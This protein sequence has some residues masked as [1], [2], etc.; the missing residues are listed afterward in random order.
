[1]R[2]RRK[3]N[4]MLIF[5]T[6]LLL[7]SIGFAALA[8]NLK[9]DGTVNVSK[10][11][12]DVH[13]ENVQV[14]Q[15]SVTATTVPTSDDTTTTE[16]TYAVNFTKP[17]DFYEFTVDI[18][19]DGTIDAMIDLVSNDLYESDGTTTKTLPA[20]LI[21]TATYN[22]GTA[23]AKNQILKAN[24]SEKIKVRIEFDPEVALTD[25]PS[26]SADSMIFKFKTNY[27]QADKNAM[28][29]RVD[30]QND[31]WADIISAYQSNNISQLTTAMNNDT[32][33]EV[34]MDLNNDSEKETYHVR[35][36]NLSK[37]NNSETS[38]TA[39]GLVLEFVETV[40]IHRI[41]ASD[42]NTGG[43]E[44]SEIRTYLN[45]PNGTDG[46][47]LN[48]IPNSLKSVIIDTAVVSGHGS[49][50]TSNFTTT[51]KL[52]LLSTK[53]V[54]GNHSESDSAKADSITRQLD[55]Y[56]N[57]NVTSASFSKAIKKTLDGIAQN[58][59]LRSADSSSNRWF[60]NVPYSTSSG[61]YTA[62]NPT[63]NTYGISPAFR[64]SE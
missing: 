6:L 29:V 53:E 43:W 21:S 32:T 9:I 3:N 56:K 35:I 34:K 5:A 10:T 30:F 24:T 47:F 26:T 38:E 39:C 46:E 58:W 44:S 18:V 49:N 54:Y 4:R 55:Y 40:T 62:A 61:F 7:I 22:D 28:P 16:I 37:C 14:T 42:T 33:K 12:W 17:G 20:Y 11:S 15:G 60:W 52:Y 23:I 51:D 1:M 13:F 64:L 59:W 8:A 50:Q 2:N 25:L 63:I 48:K 19:N 36:A 41:N 57:N 31:S 27:K 45:G